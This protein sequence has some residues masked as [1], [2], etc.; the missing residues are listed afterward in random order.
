[1][2]AEI[3]L[4][5]KYV[6]GGFAAGLLAG[7][8]GCAGV[9]EGGTDDAGDDGTR[10]GQWSEA[11]HSGLRERFDQDRDQ[12]ISNDT[13]RARLIERLNLSEVDAEDLQPLRDVN[14]DAEIL[15][16][17]GYSACMEQS[18]LVVDDTSVQVD[19]YVPEADERTD[20]G[21]SP[22]QVVVWSVPRSAFTDVPAEID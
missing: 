1:M 19:V 5:Q 16:L 6:V 3:A 8:I 4:W 22:L 14:L 17:A 21:W 7:L 10:L 12:L 2:D 15:V 11:E 18:R 9:G 13:E 20:C